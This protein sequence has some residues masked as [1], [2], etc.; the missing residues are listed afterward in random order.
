MWLRTWHCFHQFWWRQNR[1][2]TL[3]LGISSWFL[4]LIS[5]SMRFHLCPLCDGW[6]GCWLKLSGPRPRW[7]SHCQ[8]SPQLRY[9]QLGCW[10]GHVQYYPKDWCLNKSKNL[11]ENKPGNV[12]RNPFSYLYRS[13]LSE[14]PLVHVC[15]G[16]M[17]RL[18]CFF[19]SNWL[20][21]S[22]NNETGLQKRDFFK[23]ERVHFLTPIIGS[24]F[25]KDHIDRLK[26]VFIVIKWHYV[27]TS[28]NCFCST[29]FGKLISVTFS[30][31][32]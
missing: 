3:L 27:I 18:W 1:N 22:I 30:G 14:A 25:Y 24:K 16:G 23:I 7:S 29:K 32:V 9:W 26:Q 20:V 15:K 13:S 10:N 19:H 8:S 17:C 2:S 5:D 28:G 6:S 11:H 31:A 12:H 4:H 21:P